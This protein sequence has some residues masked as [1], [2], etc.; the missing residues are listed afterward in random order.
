MTAVNAGTAASRCAPA[1]AELAIPDGLASV[2]GLHTPCS[3]SAGLGPKRMLFV[4]CSSVHHDC[5]S[6]NNFKSRILLL[7]VEN[8]EV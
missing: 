8:N 1:G 6:I 3:G 2:T 5:S 4:L 7:G